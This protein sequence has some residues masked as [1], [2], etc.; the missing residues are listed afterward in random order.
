MAKRIGFVHTVGFLVENFR[1]RMKAAHPEA[2]SFHI[3]NESLLQDLLRG[4]PKELVYRRV[5]AQVVMAAEA[6]ADLIV[7]TCS[8]T[9]PA[10]DIA[11]QV[12]RQPV[13]KID[14]PMAAKAIHRG[15][16]IGLLCTASSTVEPSSSLLR[17]H[18]TRQGREALITP[19]VK[20]EAYEALMAGD[21]ARHDS[22]VCAAARGL[23]QEVDVIVLAQASLAHLQAELEATLPTPV[24]A[25]PPLLMDAISAALKI[26][27]SPAA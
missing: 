6:G 20:P 24:L 17:Q 5:V 21:R 13:L 10:V 22:I 18:A 11:R 4:A 1:Q 2:D 9:S 12:V 19:L 3:L 7:V 16:R 15:P 27:D 14:D 8:S 25:S 23:G 26:P